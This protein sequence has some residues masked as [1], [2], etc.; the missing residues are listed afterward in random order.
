MYNSDNIARVRRDEEEA[1]AQE[2][3]REREQ[4]AN[5]S[6]QRLAQLRGVRTDESR[7]ETTA[8]NRSFD[9]DNEH[10]NSK[11]RKLAGEDD[12]DRDIRLARQLAP[13]EQDVGGLA[14]DSSGHVDLILQKKRRPSDR[15]DVQNSGR[16]RDEAS[17]EGI[18]LA[19]AAGKDDESSQPW[20]SSTQ[21]DGTFAYK[22]SSQ[23]VWGN[24]D[25]RRKDRE[26]RRL[27]ANDPLSIMK[28][29]VKQLRQAEAQRKEW[30]EQRERDLVEVE[31][32]ATQDRKRRRRQE[33]EGSLDGFDL[34]NGYSKD[35]HKSREQ[36]LDRRRRHRRQH[37]H[38]HRH[39]HRVEDRSRSPER[40]H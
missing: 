19:D 20:Y 31:V 32:L 40:N 35:S 9:Q 27:D 14:L 25:P 28:K 23:D 11:R 6:D 3:Q 33:D 8:L 24:E 7:S 12:T 30:R 29:G 34:D 17:A 18:R 4:R 21:R 2:V 16:P 39:K 1:R 5:D 15:K 38:H 37:R 22:Q 26:K 36:R 13:R 10:R